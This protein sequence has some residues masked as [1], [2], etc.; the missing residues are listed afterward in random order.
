VK[1]EA[2]GVDLS[3]TATFSA[4]RTLTSSATLLASLTAVLVLVI[5]PLQI[6][7]AQAADTFKQGLQDGWTLS[8]SGMPCCG[9]LLQEE[10]T[11]MGQVG[12]R[13]VRVNLRLGA[14]FPDWTTPVSSKDVAAR[15]CDP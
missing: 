8:D 5:A 7:Q 4:W 14:C 9:Q 6:P 11:N 3:R 10:L 13:Y 15:G 2:V 12:A 1:Q